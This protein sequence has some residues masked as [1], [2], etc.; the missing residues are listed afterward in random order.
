MDLKHFLRFVRYNPVHSGLHTITNLDEGTIMPSLILSDS[1]GRWE[2][3]A[4]NHE[5][6]IKTVQ[7]L[8]TAAAAMQ[9][10]PAFDPQGID[11][12]IARPP[13]RSGTITALE[14]FQGLFM[15]QPDGLVTA[16][17]RT[18]RELVK[19]AGSLVAPGGPT[20]HFPFQALPK[21]SWSWT[22]PPRRFGAN[23]GSVNG[24][25]AH[26]GCDLYFPKGTSIHAIT[27]GV[28]TRG[29]YDFYAET[30]ALE[31]DHGLFLARY[32]EIMR[33]SPVRQ[34]DRVQAGQR[35]AALGHL[36]GITV[37][38]DMLHLEMYDKTAQGPLTVRGDD[39]K[40]HTNGRTFV[41]RR[42]LLDPTS[43]LNLWKLNLA[44]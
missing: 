12:Q 25:R 29:P 36:V 27:D 14:V 28:V 37:A 18:F 31:V 6:D 39:A 23:R 3:N 16:G 44:P 9:Q 15:N 43:F 30:F 7:T 13:R 38:S 19:A 11:G 34:G 10:N 8:L 2:K 5:A 24:N 22:T 1:V 26:A 33:G 17:G 42:D 21:P 41:R 4:V 20:F 40:K 32:G 35:I